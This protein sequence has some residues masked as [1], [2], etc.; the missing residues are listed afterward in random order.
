MID[1]RSLPTPTTKARFNSTYV[2]M[3]EEVVVHQ[4]S[5]RIT[6][7]IRPTRIVSVPRGIM[8]YHTRM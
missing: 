2:L 6:Y 1:T 7:A 8:T 4:S 5:Y 3:K